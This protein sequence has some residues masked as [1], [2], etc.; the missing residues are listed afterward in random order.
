M[1]DLMTLPQGTL[2]MTFYTHTKITLMEMLQAYLLYS[3]II[4]RASNEVE[5]QQ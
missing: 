2:I 4:A 1:K 5:W 3:Q